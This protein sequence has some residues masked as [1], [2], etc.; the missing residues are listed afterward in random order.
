MERVHANPE[1]KRILASNFR[2][3]LVGADSGCLQ[4]FT[5]K[6]LIL[7]GNKVAAEREVINRCALTP[8]VENTNLK[9][10]SPLAKNPIINIT[11]LLWD[12]AP[13]DCTVTLG[14]VYSCSSDNN[15]QDDGP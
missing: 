10:E 8:K 11:H 7:I 1:M 12:Q 2:D 15:E 9:R 3:I 13:R 6:L 14:K 4:R 5:G